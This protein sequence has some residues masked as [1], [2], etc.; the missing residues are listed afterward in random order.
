M[1][2]LYFHILARDIT[3]ESGAPQKNHSLLARIAHSADVIKVLHLALARAKR[4]GKQARNCCNRHIGST[5]TA[6]NARHI[7]YPKTQ[8]HDFDRDWLLVQVD[9][10]YCSMAVEMPR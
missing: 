7:Q 5:R 1:K 8:T 2:L 4:V 6:S 9:W 10:N 3:S